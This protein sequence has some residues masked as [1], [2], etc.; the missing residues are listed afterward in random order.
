MND[1]QKIIILFVLVLII[2]ILAFFTFKNTS[3]KCPRNENFDNS[4]QHIQ[5]AAK[6]ITTIQSI[7]QD[8]RI[9]M[10]IQSKYFGKIFNINCTTTQDTKGNYIKQFTLPV[11]TELET[12]CL[13]VGTNT[14]TNLTTC[15]NDI[16]SQLFE[17]IHIDSE[18]TL[19]N[20]LHGSNKGSIDNCIKSIPY[21]ICQSV[22][23]PQM[24]LQY[25]GGT[26]DI[27]LM[28]LGAYV[29][30]QW[31]LDHIGIDVPENALQNIIDT[32]IPGDSN[33]RINL[34]LGSVIK[35]TLQ[36][37]LTDET[38]NLSLLETD[39][40]DTLNL[41]SQH[42]SNT[43]IIHHSNTPIIHH[44]NTPIVHHSSHGHHTSHVHHSN[45]QSSLKGGWQSS[46]KGGW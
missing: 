32:N 3:F 25:N 44:S 6:T 33:I 24:A 37:V 16:H 42:L 23:H 36:N 17:L 2:I 1:Q 34:N 22:S 18:S 12:K 5:D 35:D 4:D 46:L 9:P 26:E 29:N 11:R 7:Q 27:V 43:P 40:E 31:D 45:A 41:D 13:Q 21:Y 10:A 30:Q 14:N 8:S 15:N 38:K 19:K 39:I 20:I 28:P